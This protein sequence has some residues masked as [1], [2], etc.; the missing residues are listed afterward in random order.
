M[1]YNDHIF[2]SE[3]VAM[4]AD[5]AKVKHKNES[6]KSERKLSP[7]DLEVCSRKELLM[8]IKQYC[9]EKMLFQNLEPDENMRRYFDN[10]VTLLNEEIKTGEDAD[11][12]FTVVSNILLLMNNLPEK[13]KKGSVSFQSIKQDAEPAIHHLD[14]SYKITESFE[15]L[16]NRKPILENVVRRYR[17]RKI[18]DILICL[19][20]GASLVSGGIALFFAKRNMPENTEAAN[21]FTTIGNWWKYDVLKK[22]IP[23]SVMEKW[24]AISLT[25]TKLMMILLVAFAL[26]IIIK[27]AY[28]SYIHIIGRKKKKIEQQWQD[29]Q[30]ISTAF[31]NV[32]GELKELEDD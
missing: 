13:E 6:L 9:T 5:N 22:Q 16:Q 27:I 3:G 23:I 24:R 31:T 26:I 20:G 4:A 32:A 12:T 7:E 28:K 11:K 15:K 10:T 19:L 29:F 14:R 30:I 18:V 2:K 1:W 25:Y 21:V 8:L 17:L